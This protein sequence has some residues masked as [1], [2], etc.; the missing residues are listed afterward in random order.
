METCRFPIAGEDS[1]SGECGKQAKNA[2]ERFVGMSKNGWVIREPSRRGLDAW[3]SREA[4]EKEVG[5]GIRGWLSQDT[6]S[7]AKEIPKAE[8]AFHAA[9]EGA[10]GKVPLEASG[11]AGDF[12]DAQASEFGAP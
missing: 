8:D 2:R 10:V 1:G 12:R 4:G 5:F 7:G 11:V 9:E 6:S 3:G